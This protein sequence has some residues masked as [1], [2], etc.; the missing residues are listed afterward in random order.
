MTPRAWP[1]PFAATGRAALDKMRRDGLTEALS[2]AALGRLFWTG[3]ALDLFRR[4][5]DELAERAAEIAA[6]RRLRERTPFSRS[7]AP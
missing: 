6:A 7:P 3:F 2:T 1:R 4:D 5:L